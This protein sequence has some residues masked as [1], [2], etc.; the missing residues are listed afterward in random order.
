MCGEIKPRSG[1]E[2]AGLPGA[3]A[4]RLSTGAGRPGHVWPL[5]RSATW[6]R[7]V[8]RGRAPVAW[9]ME[10]PPRPPSHRPPRSR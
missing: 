10:A 8:G 9:W 4:E 2:G 5:P 3:A 6:A 1:S 7:A